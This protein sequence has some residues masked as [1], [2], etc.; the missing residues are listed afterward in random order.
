M[1]IKNNYLMLFILLIYATNSQAEDKSINQKVNI[2]Q[3]IPYMDVID[4]GKHIRIERIQD[5]AN[6]ISNSFAKTSRPCPPFCIQPFKVGGRTKTVG[7]IEV[8]SFIKNK[9]MTG[10]GLLIDARTPEW[11]EKSTIPT[12]INIPFYLFDH[13]S[14]KKSNKKILALLGVIEKQDDTDF[15]NAKELMIF[16][17]G[18]WCSQAPRAINNLIRQGYLGNKLYWYRGGLQNWLMLGLKPKIT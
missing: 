4:H 16:C 13:R 2:T 9:V 6:K 11:F 10:K 1:K 3:N 18:S 14:H 5:V 17:N 15:S 12:A 7:E 8:L